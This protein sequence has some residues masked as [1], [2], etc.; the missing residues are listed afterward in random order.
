MYKFYSESQR[1]IPLPPKYSFAQA[2]NYLNPETN[3]FYILE[4]NEQEYIQC[5]GSKASCT[6]EVRL[7]AENSAHVRFTVGHRTGQED[8]VH[9]PMS[10]GGV[11]V[12]A[13]EV[14]SHREAVRLFTAFFA[15]E[16]F[17]SEY[18]RRP[19]G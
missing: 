6:V 1:D 9:T 17:A 19:R 14:L 15:G 3:S 10:D 5:G 11:F 18:S 12:L 2:F 16:P 7:A 8:L 4:R 13:R